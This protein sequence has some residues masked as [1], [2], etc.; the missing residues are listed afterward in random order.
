MVDDSGRDRRAAMCGSLAAFTIPQIDQVT[1]DRHSE[2]A[3]VLRRYR[4]CTE[5]PSVRRAV[6]TIVEGSSV[7]GIGCSIAPEQATV[8]IG[9]EVTV[10]TTAPR[11]IPAPAEHRTLR[12]T[13]GSGCI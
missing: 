12:L 13:S 1:S 6:R 10:M 4:W 2:P 3:K 5:A 8:G 7:F 9:D 11:L